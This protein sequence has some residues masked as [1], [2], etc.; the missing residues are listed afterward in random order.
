MERCLLITGCAGFIGMNLFEKL[1]C[2]DTIQNYDLILSI[3]KFGYA[4]KYNKEFYFEN[5]KKLNQYI[6]V[7]TIKS[8]IN[9]LKNISEYS[10]ININNTDSIVIM[11]LASESHV[12]NSIQNPF[13]IY[14][15]N[16]KIPSSLLKFIGI[17]NWHK[18]KKYYHISTDEVYS[19]IPLEDIHDY[20][21]WFSE[22]N[23]INPNNPYSASKAAQDCFLMSMKHT[24]NIPV[25]FI[26]MANQ[27][28]GKYQHPE[29]MLM[30]SILRVLK[31]EPV[32]IYG[33]GTNVRQWTPV[34]ITAQILADVINN[35]LDFDGV[36][37]IANKNGV[38]N[39]NEIIDLLYM[40]M[41]EYC[42]E[43]KREFIKYSSM[44]DSV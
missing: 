14:E 34:S 12:D 18:I 42:Y 41:K 11:S 16:S 37:H 39:K 30:A 27:Q 10:S 35:K 43:L 20:E 24:F 26:R 36:L 17:D 3:D 8:N 32:K 6:N 33:N 13:S 29:K 15:E 40:N 4:S 31:G 1:L 28:P 44:Y 38:K 7:K 5:E 23:N 22:K 9:N 25:K 2:N 19:E 21:K